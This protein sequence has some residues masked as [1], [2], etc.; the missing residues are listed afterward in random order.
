[1]A[2]GFDRSSFGRNSKVLFMWTRAQINIAPVRPDDNSLLIIASGKCSNSAEFQPFA[3]RLDSH[4]MP[5][6]L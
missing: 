5:A 2:T 6:S 1:M 4:T 3:A